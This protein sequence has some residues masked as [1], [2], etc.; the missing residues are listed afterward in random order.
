MHKVVTDST[1]LKKLSDKDETMDIGRLFHNQDGE[2]MN[3]C[4]WA[5]S[6]DFEGRAGE[7]LLRN[8]CYPGVACGGHRKKRAV[9]TRLVLSPFSIHSLLNFDSCGIPHDSSTCLCQSR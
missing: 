6:V 2:G 3:E 5:T 9:G 7:D 8:V 4:R 1:H